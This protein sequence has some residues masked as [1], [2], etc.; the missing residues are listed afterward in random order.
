MNGAKGIVQGEENCRV[1]VQRDHQKE[2]RTM[3]VTHDH[4]SGLPPQNGSS[5]GSKEQASSPQTRRAWCTDCYTQRPEDGTTPTYKEGK[6]TNNGR[7]ATAIG[8]LRHTT[9]DRRAEG[10]GNQT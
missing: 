10:Q 3:A 1:L 5:R 4:L 2:G 9:P 6:G 8:E 7:C